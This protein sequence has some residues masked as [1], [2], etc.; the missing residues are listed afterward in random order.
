[1]NQR[2]TVETHRMDSRQEYS[3]DRTPGEHLRLDG[4]RE[5][6]RVFGMVKLGLNCESVFGLKGYLCLDDM[7]HHHLVSIS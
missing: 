6:F 4:D 2:K 5:R 1:M 7:A 3:V